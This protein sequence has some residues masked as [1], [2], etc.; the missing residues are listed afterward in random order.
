MLQATFSALAAMLKHLA[1]HL[2]GH[3][4]AMLQHTARLRYS[5]VQHVRSLAAKAM[6]FLLRRGV[7]LGAWLL[8][9]LM[10][11]A[12]AGLHA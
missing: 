4:P 12:A 3:I 9:R 7:V 10:P 11:A 1:K 2:V 5:P 6:G 8:R